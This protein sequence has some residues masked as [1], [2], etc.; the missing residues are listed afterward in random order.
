MKINKEIFK[1]YGVITAGAFLVA[2]GVYF[3]K[4]PNNFS[5]GGVTGISMIASKYLPAILSPS[6]LSL[7][8]N[9]LILLI[10]F[11]VLGKEVGAKTA[12]ASMFM[13]LSLNL[14]EALFPMSAPFTDQPLLELC[15]AVILPAVGSAL[16]FNCAASTGGTDIVAMILKKYSS[17]DIGKAL[18]CSDGIIVALTYF[19]FGVKTGLLATLGLFAKALLVDNVI[20]SINAHKYFFIVTTK[21]DEICDF[22]NT[23]LHK[24]AT[25]WSAEG[26]YTGDERK[27]ILA[28]M[29]R[30]QA[31]AVKRQVK[32]IDP[33]SFTLISN[34]SEIIGKGFRTPV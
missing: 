30:A 12:Y 20:E 28:V 13:S 19:V 34:T 24:G 18:L 25:V 22:I 26:S 32:K 7:I 15:F 16:L 4:F 33:H 6:L 9:V 29:T 3:F 5:T 27:V 17:L 8:I 21:P 11:V 31:I 2:A 14:L 23:T 10:G 1:E